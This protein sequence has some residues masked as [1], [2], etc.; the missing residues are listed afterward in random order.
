LFSR[1][2][3]GAWADEKLVRLKVDSNPNVQ[4]ESLSA[5][6][7]K[8]DAMK[9]AALAMKKRY[10]VLGHP[11]LILLNPS[12]EV[13]G[14]YRGYKRGDADFTWGLI[15]QG[16]IGAMTAHRSWRK[17]L[18]KKGYREWQDNKGRKVFAK[19]VSYHKGDLVLIEPDG[20]RSK[21]K[22]D[23]LSSQDR[24]WIK[25]QKMLRGIE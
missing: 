11:T 7:E 8:E 12:G 4:M 6:E 18:E 17:D 21:T 25:Q 24:E 10:K 20:L 13:V 15:K 19:L 23:R 22:E 16:E 3:F 9:S 14:K 2:D 1:A 5:Q